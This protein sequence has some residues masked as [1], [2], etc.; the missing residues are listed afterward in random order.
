MAPRD[1]A[2]GAVLLLIAFLTF[3]TIRAIVQGSNIGLAIVSLIILL[4]LGFGVLGAL[5]SRPDE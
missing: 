5:T 4:L 2:L 3:F 1:F